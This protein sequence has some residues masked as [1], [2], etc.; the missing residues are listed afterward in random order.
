M[1]YNDKNNFDKRGG[2][3]LP[4]ELMER[5]AD[6]VLVPDEVLVAVLFKIGVHGLN[7]IERSRR[8]IEVFGSMSCLSPAMGAP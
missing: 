5:V 3:L 1:E 2:E 8:F 6:S 4:R 7:V